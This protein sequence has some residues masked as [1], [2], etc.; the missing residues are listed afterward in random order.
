MSLNI[1]QTVVFPLNTN[2]GNPCPVILNGDGL[3]TDDMQDLA[4]QLGHET[5][6]V[7]SS[8]RVDC[9]FKFRY[10]VPNFEMEMCVHATVGSVTVLIEQ[11]LIKKSPLNIQ[12][13]L[14][15]IEVSWEKNKGEIEVEVAQFLPKISDYVPTT[16]E[17]CEALN[18]KTTELSNDHVQSVSTS[19]FKLMVPLKSLDTLQN[20]KPNYDKLWELCDQYG[21]TG[22]YPYAIENYAQKVIQARQ[23]PNNA[24]YVEDPATGVAASALGAYFYLHEIF[25]NSPSGW[26]TYHIKQGIAMG[27]PSYLQARIYSEH[28]MIVKTGI[29][30]KAVIL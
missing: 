20:L 29:K 17:I 18:I 27:K 1:F 30:G 28:G 9:D 7:T 2:G 10:F 16:I 14:G 21:F 5:C 26:H 15:P 3:T 4:K 25:P 13:L 19:R 23:F 6:F 11:G 12:T 22:F 24:G 8:D